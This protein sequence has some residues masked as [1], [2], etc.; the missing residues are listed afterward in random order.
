MSKN[1]VI[2][3]VKMCRN[4]VVLLEN[5]WHTTREIDIIYWLRHVLET[6]CS[7]HVLSFKF[8]FIHLRL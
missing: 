7:N 8:S 1:P 6:C 3:I 2:E 4:H 5:K